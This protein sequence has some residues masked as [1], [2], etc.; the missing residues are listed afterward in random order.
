MPNNILI[1][2]EKKKKKKSCMEDDGAQGEKKTGS[3]SVLIRTSG[4]AD[5]ALQN[6]R[7]VLNKMPASLLVI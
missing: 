3:L 7:C 4:A 5:D 6:H 1:F 2:P